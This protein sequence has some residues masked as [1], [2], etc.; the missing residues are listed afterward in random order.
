[1]SATNDNRSNTPHAKNHTA[2][3][4]SQAVHTGSHGENGTLS[5][6]GDNLFSILK[7]WLY[8]EPDIVFRELGSNALDAIEK[9]AQGAFALEQDTAGA[10][11]ASLAHPLPPG[12]VSDG[13]DGAVAGAAAATELGSGPHVRFSPRVLVTLD[14]AAKTLTFSDNGIGM[15]YEQVQKYINTIA[16]SGAREFVKRSDARG[17]GGIIGH[18]GV[19]FY[20]AFMYAD[21]VAIETRSCT[22]GPGEGAVRWDCTADMNFTMG[23]CGKEDIGT[24]V[25]L[26]LNEGNPYLRDPR[27]ALAALR[28]YFIFSHYPVA[29]LVPGQDPV[30][31]NHPNP[32]WRQNPDTVTEPDVAAFYKGFFGDTKDPL[33]WLPFSSIDIGIRGALFFRDTK[34]GTEELDGQVHIYNRGV[35]VGKNIPSLIPKFVNLQSGILECDDL[36]LAVSRSDVREDSGPDALHRIYECLSQEVSIALYEMFAKSR[37]DFEKYWPEL[38]AFVKYGVMQDK[39]FAGVM[40]KRIIF[41]DITGRYLTIDEYLHETA[42]RSTIYYASDALDQAHYIRIFRE[43]GVNALLFDHVIDQPLLFRFETLYPKC[44]FTRIDSDIGAIY[45]GEL[46][47]GDVRNAKQWERRVLD[48]IGPR[49]GDIAPRFTRLAFRDVSALIVNDEN[50]RRMA[51]MMEL[52]GHKAHGTGVRQAAPAANPST[53]ATK[54]TATPSAPGTG[55]DAAPAAAKT[56]LFNLANPIVAAALGTGGPQANPAPPTGGPQATPALGTGGPQATLALGTGGPQTNP[57]P[58]TD[59]PGDAPAP[60]ANAPGDAPAPGADIPSKSSILLNHLLDI[61]LL[62]QQALGP[63]D[64][65]NFLARSEEILTLLVEDQASAPAPQPQP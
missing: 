27:H 6:A 36:P 37:G 58:P 20:S 64:M 49:L 62:A 61:A 16:F 30:Q 47:A 59:A 24:D 7:N 12:E 18:F 26:Y 65:E 42:P 57:A 51:D 4:D 10:G 23:S 14:A 29:F 34:Y 22:G 39:T 48:C 55:A 40:M 52:Y 54:G 46:T 3:S 43:C 56:L 31:I 38:N 1:M 33:F 13:G 45:G 53:P 41:E 17:Q 8:T 63:E 2:P 28:K 15:T 35:Y 21:H 11:G 5:I 19:G 9:R 32:I 60:G 50:A 25:I 44:S